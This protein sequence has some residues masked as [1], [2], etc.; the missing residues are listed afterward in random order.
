MMDCFHNEDIFKKVTKK[1]KKLFSLKTDRQHFNRKAEWRIDS[2][3]INE[4]NIDWHFIWF[5]LYLVY[6]CE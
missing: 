4:E 5:F 1:E 3:S 2:F 6:Q